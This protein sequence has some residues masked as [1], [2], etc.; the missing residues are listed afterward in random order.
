ME[1]E[2]KEVNGGRERMDVRE[3]GMREVD[4]RD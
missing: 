4:V 2:W 3:S 1:K